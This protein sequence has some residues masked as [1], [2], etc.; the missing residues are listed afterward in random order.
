MRSQTVVARRRPLEKLMMLLSNI[1]KV[2]EF[3][4]AKQDDV[5]SPKATNMD[6]DEE[7]VLTTVNDDAGKDGI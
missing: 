4:D 5:S 2:E 7:V 1:G 3:V 6:A